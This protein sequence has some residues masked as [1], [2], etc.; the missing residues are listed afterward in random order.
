MSATEASP[1]EPG[2]LFVVAT[3]I[4]NLGDLTPRALDVLRHADILAAEDTRVLRKLATAH[5]VG[6]GARLTPVHD[7]NE[8]DRAPWLVQQLQ[9]GRTVGLF[10]DAGTPLV[11]DPG[12]AVVRA[13]VEA[14]CRVVPVPG[15]SALLCALV[16]SGLPTDDVRFC[17]FLPRQRGKRASA[18]AALADAPSTLVFYEAQQRVLATVADLA[19]ALGDRPAAACC[20][21]TKRGER[22]HR[23]PLPAVLAALEATAPLTGEWVL[24]VGGA[25]PAP[26]S[27]GLPAEAERLIDLLLARQMGAR[28]VRDLVCAT[29][30]TH[31]KDT[32]AA[33]LARGREA[34][35]PR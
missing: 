26:A 2:C 20:D 7:H 32:Y 22:A 9:A 13:V 27:T 8:R 15:A 33:V 21:L 11:S 23:G 12:F 16:L 5:G 28:E 19:H 31:K 10:S 3:P 1:L 30:G 14:G 18:I 4:G 17:G 35:A 29:F 34:P 6:S 25:P 24:V